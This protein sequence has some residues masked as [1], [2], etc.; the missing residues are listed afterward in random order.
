M[1]L[2]VDG[3]AHAARARGRSIA[4]VFGALVGIGPAAVRAQDGQEVF[5][6]PPPETA[7]EHT[8]LVHPPFA[9]TLGI[10]RARSVH[11]RLFLGGR[12]DFDDPQGV[13]AVKF[14]TDDDPDAKADDFQLTLLGVNAGRGEVLYNSSM[15]TLAIFGREGG[16]EGQFR[17]PHGIAAHPDGRVYVADRGNGRVARLRWD[18]TG[19]R[20]VWAGTWPAAAPFDVAVDQRGNVFV[21]DRDADAVLRFADS[22]AGAG[23]GLLPPSPV[24][25]SRWPLP[26]DVDDPVGLAIGDSLDVWYRPDHYRLYLVDQGGARLRAYDAE[27]RVLAEASPAGV[28]GGRF[29]YLALDYHGNVYVTDPQRE[30]VVKLDSELALL[31]VF[32]GPGDTESAFEDPRGIAIWRRFGQVFVAERQGAQYLFVG[33]DVLP[34]DGPLAVRRGE[35]RWSFEIFLTE[36]ADVTATFLDGAGDTLAVVAPERPFDTGTQLVSWDDAAWTRPPAGNWEARAAT[37]VVQAR[38]TYSSR[39]KFARVRE[40]TIVWQDL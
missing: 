25:G 27:G 19:R 13:A 28:G 30:A 26:A 39:R 38:P 5:E 11:L 4:L 1:I 14:A 37:L 8:T 15:Q 6:T 40:F 22:A 36:A 21:T 29:G 9:H 35:G 18:P 20:L 32:P 31:A 16:E 34:A 10:H 12:T 17:D 33:T 2:F 3:I 23:T 24:E 7:P